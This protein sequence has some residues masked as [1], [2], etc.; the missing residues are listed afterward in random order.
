MQ[1]TFISNKTKVDY[2]QILLFLIFLMSF[3]GFVVLFINKNKSYKMNHKFL[4][5]FLLTISFIVFET[6]LLSLYGSDSNSPIIVFLSYLFY[7]VIL[8]VGPLVYLYIK[9][10]SVELQDNLTFSENLK[11]FTLP[12]LLLIVNIFSFFALR[13]FDQESQNY[14]L[15]SNI[16]TYLNF[17]TFFIVF[18]VQNT[19]YLYLS[20]RMFQS[21]EEVYQI[22]KE[23]SKQ[24]LLWIK[25]FLIGYFI[26]IVLLYLFQTSP[27]LPG[28]FI[29]RIS[30]LLYVLSI[31]IF[32]NRDYEELFNDKST[33]ENVLDDA[34]KIKLKEQV[35]HAIHVE[36]VYLDPDMNLQMFA[37]KVNSNTKYIS[38]FINQEYNKS[39]T[40]FI[41]EMRIEEAKRL[42][43]DEETKNYTLETIGIMSG[44]NSKSSFNAAFKKHYNQTP[45]EFREL[46]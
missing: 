18:L 32:G 1:I 42:L 23:T 37:Q 45:S 33:N 44:F 36:K 9:S 46:N 39:F 28:K 5:Y 30:V 6:L 24:T 15:L 17:T 2:R 26:I 31:V 19:I 14:L 16:L 27:F 25:Y 40:N 7:S 4:G 38:K 35:D 41:N 43:L 3:G 21:H 29:F 8:L 22:D 10:F 11:H 13:T 34:I 20:T 12:I